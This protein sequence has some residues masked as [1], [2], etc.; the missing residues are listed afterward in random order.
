MTTSGRSAEQMR[1]GKSPEE[2]YEEREGRIRA[3]IELKEPDR[4]PV[5]LG[6][7]YFMAKYAGLDFSAAYYDMPAW[8]EAFKKTILDF[9]PDAF[10][11]SIEPGTFGS[12]MAASGTAYDLLGALQT[13]WPGRTLPANVGHQFV[14]GEYMM[15][16]EYDLF[17]SDPSDFTLRFYLP[18]VYEALR[19]FAKL[20]SPKM[21]IAGN[22]FA[23]ATPLFASPEFQQ[24]FAILAKAGQEQEKWRTAGMSLGD[25][26]ATLGFPASAHGPDAGGAPFD[27]I[28]DYLRGM[29]GSMLDMY[30]RPEKLLAACEMILEW[31][32]ASMTPADP[33]ERGNPKIAGGALHRGS[34]GFMSKKQFET[35]YWP[36]LKKL[37]LASIDM[38][39]VPCPFFEGTWTERLEYLL[40][41]PKGKMI[42]RFADTDMAKAK[43]VLGDSFCIVGNVP[44]SL[45]QAGSPQEVEDYCRNLIKVV[46]KGGGFILRSSSD[47]IDEAK[48][49]NVKAMVDS[50]KSYGWY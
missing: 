7:T 13:R 44:V 12:G 46:G 38:G 8:K 3:A 26:L 22:A 20:S 36:S 6:G 11:S 34:D 48:P 4:V 1:T 28:S 31:R 45:L 39:Y 29:R 25:E 14:E 15:G 50:V 23:A 37:I 40:E 9:E 42:C 21:W 16:D 41:I 35:F 24:L 33:N 5:V 47:A 49:A 2:L 18:R 30:R 43:A 10:G 27:V 17:L 19:P 32:V